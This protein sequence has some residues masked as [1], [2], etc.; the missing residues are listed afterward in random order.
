[1]DT[2]LLLGIFAVV[3]AVFGWVFYLIS[4]MRTQQSKEVEVLKGQINALESQA[5]L[6]VT[7][8]LERRIQITESELERLRE[9]NRRLAEAAKVLIKKSDMIDQLVRYYGGGSG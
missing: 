1:M 8:D 2:A 5:P 9:D 4:Q 7:E 6:K 3:G